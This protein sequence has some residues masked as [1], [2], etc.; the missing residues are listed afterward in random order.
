M[1]V[2]NVYVK[3]IDETIAID[4]ANYPTV[5]RDYAEEY[6]WRQVLSDSAAS[7][8]M[9]ADVD[10]KRVPLKGSALDKARA[11]ARECVY[12]KLDNLKSGILRRVRTGD[13]VMAEAK[14]IAYRLV[15]KDDDF[16]TWAAEAGVKPGDK[17][18]AD[19]V[20][21]LSAER[22][23]TDDRIIEIAERRVAEMA[24]LEA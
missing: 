13:A 20:A 8:S 11:E 7:V 15:Q 12:K 6:G 21:R 19:E 18:Y 16:R 4:T 2:F 14:R 1:P 24:E 3:K 10:G 9:T 5:S 23:E 17:A 22:I